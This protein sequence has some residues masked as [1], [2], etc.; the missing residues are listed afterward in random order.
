MVSETREFVSEECKVELLG[1]V[2]DS[3][4]DGEDDEDEIG[5]D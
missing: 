2:Y 1:P 4:D 5:R 3:D